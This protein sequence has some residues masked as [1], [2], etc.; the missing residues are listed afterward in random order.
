[1]ASIGQLTPFVF[2]W[3]R[4]GACFSGIQSV[5]VVMMC[6]CVGVCGEVREV[7]LHV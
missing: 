3:S 2:M 6:G 7:G 1:M 5:V 4:R